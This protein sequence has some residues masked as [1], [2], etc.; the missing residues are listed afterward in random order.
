MA[1]EAATYVSGLNA[2]NPTG[3]DDIKQGDDHLRLLKSVLQAT[4]PTASR[5]LYPD[6]AEVTV[7][8]AGV[9]DVLGAATD[10]VL[11]SG[12]TTITSFG[13]GTNRMKFVRFSGALTLTHDATSLIL[14]GGANITTAAGDTCIVVS[15]ASSNCRVYAYQK[16]SGA[17]IVTTDTANPASDDG[18]SLGTTALK[19]SDL[20]LASGAVINF[21]SGNYTITH[22][23]GS[24][25]FS[26]ALA[27]TGLLSALSGIEVGH[28]SDTTLTRL[29]AGNLGVEGNL[30][31]RAGGTD[32]PL[33]DGGTGASDA[34]TART[35]LG[36]AIGS[37]VGPVPTSSTYPIGFS[38][39]MRYK[40]SSSL[41]DGATTSG[42]NV[43][44]IAYTGDFGSYGLNIASGQVQTGTWKNINGS[45]LR[46]ISSNND[47]EQVGRL[48]RTA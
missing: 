18:D 20:F 5:A 21:N 35:N 23:A 36:L 27:L 4:F 45:T 44:T 43:E 12:T 34:S 9:C 47:G 19:W 11:V 8:S 22:S 25:A 13:T 32:V 1:L 2:S 46:R 16:A 48:V 17:A 41:A 28:A 26:G 42:T 30:L 29:S 38:G 7:A 37:D 15:D 31:Y 14:P 33:T 6:A 39:I 3:S 40:G 10:R 24:L